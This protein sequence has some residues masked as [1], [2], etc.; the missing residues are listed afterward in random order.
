MAYANACQGGMARVIEMQATVASLSKG[1]KHISR[2]LL[3]N[4]HPMCPP[5]ATPLNPPDKHQDSIHITPYTHTT[6][7]IL[8]PTWPWND[9]GRRIVLLH[10][11]PLLTRETF[12]FGI[13]LLSHYIQQLFLPSHLPGV[14]RTLRGVLFPNNAPGKSSL[15]PPSSHDEFVALRKRAAG[16]LLGLLPTGVAKV[17]LG[18]TQGD[19]GGGSGGAMLDGMED[20]L[21]V[22]NDEYYNKHLMYSVLELIL[23]RLMPELGEKGVSEL[24]EERLG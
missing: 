22:L 16:A 19:S 21:M 20:L 12:L 23:V 6:L 8:T 10:E 2:F 13:S 14:L 7:S 4:C 1:A 11:D 18:G 17:Y 3:E 15:A 5:I 24:W 9:T